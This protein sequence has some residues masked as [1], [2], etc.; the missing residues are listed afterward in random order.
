MSTE[1]DNE[2][3]K[4]LKEKI[5]INTN[6]YFLRNQK[7][8]TQQKLG[9]MLGY[10]Y[11]TIGNWEKGIRTPDAIDL[12]RLSRI[13]DVTTDDLIKKDLRFDIKEQQ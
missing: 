1:S 11:T 2:K 13:F 3:D 10:K 9:S 12:Y 4:I 6:I 5:F 8:I 7:K